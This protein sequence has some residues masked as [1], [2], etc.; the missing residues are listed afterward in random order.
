MFTF[1]DT[2][3]DAER[4]QQRMRR[5]LKNRNAVKIDEFCAL[6]GV[7]ES[8]LRKEL[9]GMLEK[10]EIERLRPVGYA[11][12]DD[13]F[14]RLVAPAAVALRADDGRTAKIV[15]E[16]FERMRLAGDGVACLVD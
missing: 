4:L 13:D 6:V 9:D 7:T 3:L 16:W 5:V 15:Q 10:G 11:R 14:F 1:I 8:E 2:T 12:A